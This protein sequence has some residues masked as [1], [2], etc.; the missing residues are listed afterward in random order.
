M[1]DFK[2]QLFPRLFMVLLMCCLPCCQLFADSIAVKT[3]ANLNMR[4]LPSTKGAVRYVIPEGTTITVALPAED[5]W[6]GTSYKGTRGY[7]SENYVHPVEIV[8]S[9]KKHSGRQPIWL[10]ILKIA[11]YGFWICVAIV[12]MLVLL[13]YAFLVI[14]TLFGVLAR[15]FTLTFSLVSIPIMLSNNMQRLLEKPWMLFYRTNSGNNSRNAITRRVWSVAKIPLYVLLTPLRFINAVT[16]NLCIHVPFEM[17]NYTVEVFLPGHEKEGR[18][19]F[20]RWLLFMPWRIVKYPLWHGMLTIV[21]S[22]IWTVVDTFIPALTLYHGTD[23][24]ASQ[25]IVRSPDRYTDYKL[26]DI[27]IWRVG[28]GNYAGDGIYFAPA[29]STAVHYANHGSLIVARVSLGCT[30]ELGMAPWHV[31][32]A[33]GKPDAHVV[34]DWGL[35]NG[36]TTGLWWRGDCHWWEYCMYDWQNRYNFSWRIRPLYVVHLDNGNIQRIPGGMCHWLFREMVIEDILT[37]ID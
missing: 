3:T 28:G 23:E 26:R 2:N 4:T 32:N 9:D 30:L 1:H 21:E 29:R 27:G 22:L 37:I 35:K 18:G 13:Y 19:Q 24:H 14:A 8:A 20:F 7:V 6:Y 31:Y 17:F 12:I 36:Y 11:W 15:V 34:T 25:C 10:S 33:C 5:G 16:Y